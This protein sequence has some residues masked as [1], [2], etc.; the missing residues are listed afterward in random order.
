VVS[1]YAYVL[2][3]LFWL[4]C[5]ASWIIEANGVEAYV[6]AFSGLSFPVLILFGFRLLGK[7]RLRTSP[8]H[9]KIIS[10]SQLAGS[11]TRSEEDSGAPCYFC[12]AVKAFKAVDVPL[13][14]PNKQKRIVKV[15]TCSSCKWI[16]DQGSVGAAVLGVMIWLATLLILYTVYFDEIMHLTNSRLVFRLSAG[17]ALVFITITGALLAWLM[18]RGFRLCV[19]YVRGA[20]HWDIGKHPEITALVKVGYQRDDSLLG[21]FIRSLEF[22]KK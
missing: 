1:T 14:G 9:A 7:W 22:F 21:W 17:G 18:V 20:S 19:F 12:S 16:Y 2:F 3:L 6:I 4:Y 11:S 5:V 13:S 15:P 8:H 10:D